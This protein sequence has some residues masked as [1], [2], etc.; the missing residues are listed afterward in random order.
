MLSNCEVRDCGGAGLKAEEGSALNLLNCQVADYLIIRSIDFEIQCSNTTPASNCVYTKRSS[1]NSRCNP[2][3]PSA[4]LLTPFLGSTSGVPSSLQVEQG[5]Q[6]DVDDNG[7][8]GNERMPSL[9]LA[10]LFR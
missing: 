10:W 1:I 8:D 5:V 9:L 4:L 2:A 6:V 7:G 3:A